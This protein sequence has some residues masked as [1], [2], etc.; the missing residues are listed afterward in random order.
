MERTK[1]AFL[2]GFVAVAASVFAVREA[3]ILATGIPQHASLALIRG[4]LEIPIP[5]INTVLGYVLAAIGAVAVT[6]MTYFVGKCIL[7]K[8]DR[9]PAIGGFAL[10]YGMMAVGAAGSSVIFWLPIAAVIGAASAYLANKIENFPAS[11][12]LSVGTT[13][14]LGVTAYMAVGHGLFV[15]AIVELLL[16]LCYWLGVFAIVIRSLCGEDA[17]DNYEEEYY[18]AN[19]QE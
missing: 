18:R 14:I 17:E 19:G 7:D 12:A 16:L 6:G 8:K 1:K 11:E 4:T 13:M 15:A 5:Q 10:G 9:V 2:I 3:L